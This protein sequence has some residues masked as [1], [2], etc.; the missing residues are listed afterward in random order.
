MKK[1]LFFTLT[2]FLAFPVFANSSKTTTTRTYDSTTT[3][4]IMGTERDSEMLESQEEFEDSNL[5]QRDLDQQRMEDQW[6]NDQIEQE[7]MEE[8]IETE[9]AI[10]YNDRTRTD[11]ERKALN[12]SSDA[13]DDQ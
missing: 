6:H 8:R 5:N 7:R 11:R 10:D 9:G 3:S 1:L 12:T 2:T 13:S 4:P